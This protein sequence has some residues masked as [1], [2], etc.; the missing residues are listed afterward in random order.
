MPTAV[1]PEGSGGAAAPKVS[2]WDRLLF[3]VPRSSNGGQPKPRLMDRLNSAV[4]KP[5]DPDAPPKN[6]GA[7]ELS[8]EELESELKEI[9]DKERAI[10]LLAGPVATLITFFVIHAKVVSDPPARL[11]DGAINRLHVN[12]STYQGPFW[13]L[14]ILSFGITGMA[15]WRK[16]LPLGIVTAMYGLT[17]FNFGYLGFG[18]PF[19]M[20]GAWYLVRTYRLHR[21]LKE[22]T[23]D[24]P[25]TTPTRP[26]P[27]KRYTPPR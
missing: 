2:L 23:A 1:D 22:S 19:V 17:I 9:N 8:G 12:P 16:R 6:P 5:A 7:Y 27:N 4:I 14:I 11:A 15:L 24:G 3:R 21:N 10:G 20:V 25:S 18:V 26:A 13:V